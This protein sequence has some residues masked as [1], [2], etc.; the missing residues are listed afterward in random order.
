MPKEKTGESC[1][2]DEVRQR[3]DAK[4]RIQIP[5]NFANLEHSRIGPKITACPPCQPDSPNFESI[6]NHTN[7]RLL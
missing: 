2:F 6:N 4:H 7:L 3:Y 1:Y 5:S